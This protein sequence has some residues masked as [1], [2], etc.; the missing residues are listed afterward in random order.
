[1]FNKRVERFYS[2]R[3]QQRDILMSHDAEDIFFFLVIN[4]KN[5]RFFIQADE[6]TDFT[7]RCHFTI[8]EICK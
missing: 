3:E 6:S 7:N 5:N 2:Q 4:G 1:M 8:C